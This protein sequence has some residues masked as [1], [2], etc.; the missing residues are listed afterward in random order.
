M[1]SGPQQ[2]DRQGACHPAGRADPQ[3]LSR[4]AHRLW[5]CCRTQYD[6]VD[7]LRESLAKMLDP[8]LVGACLKQFPTA[9]PR[10]YVN[11]DRFSK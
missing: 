10:Y 4:L 8:Q 5:R 3:R 6:L 9:M 2:P 7:R 1:G 11:P